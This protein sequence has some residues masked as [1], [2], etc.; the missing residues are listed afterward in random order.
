MT[1]LRVGIAISFQSGRHA[2]APPNQALERTGRRLAHHGRPI[3][4]AGRSTP[5]RYAD[6]V[7]RRA[8]RTMPGPLMLQ[9][10]S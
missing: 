8:L 2:E 9:I 1:D 10:I 5:G 7:E 4:A 6:Q 3:R